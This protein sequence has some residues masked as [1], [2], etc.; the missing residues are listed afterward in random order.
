MSNKYDI[1]INRFMQIFK[2]EISCE[3]SDLVIQNIV[4][5]LDKAGLKEMLNPTNPV[6]VKHDND[7]ISTNT[8][9]SD[10]RIK[11]LSNLNLFRQEYR[12]ANPTQRDNA[13]ILGIWR[14][15]PESEKE[16]YSQRAKEINQRNSGF[17]R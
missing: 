2:Q 6:V 15:M 4:A 16:Q 3:N 14:D 7:S 10:E 11:K 8:S 12:Q 9:N 13:V 1:L 17:T 5:L